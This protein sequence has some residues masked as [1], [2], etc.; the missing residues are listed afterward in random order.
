MRENFLT[1]LITTWCHTWYA[2]SEQ[3]YMEFEQNGDFVIQKCRMS[4]QSVFSG[5]GTK[6]SLETQLLEL[7]LLVVYSF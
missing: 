5:G 2:K 6:T 3:I 4:Y 7:L 1:N